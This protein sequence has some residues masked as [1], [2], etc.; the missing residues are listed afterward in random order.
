[1]D[2]ALYWDYLWFWY[3]RTIKAELPLLVIGIA[4]LGVYV[5]YEA[6]LS[7][8]LICMIAGFWVENFSD[9][10]DELIHAVERHSLPIYVIFFTIAGASINLPALYEMWFLATI[11]VIGRLIFTFIATWLGCRL[12]GESK[13][14]QKSRLGRFCSPGR[15]YP[16]ISHPD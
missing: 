13:T 16:R 14:I 4:F 15:C 5:S 1:M 6:H 11:L 8:L 7:G 12:S 2:S 10:G 9:F 3:I